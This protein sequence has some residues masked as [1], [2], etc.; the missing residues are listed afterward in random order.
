MLAMLALAAV[1]S[2]FNKSKVLE[3]PALI[4]LPSPTDGGDSGS[5]DF[6]INS[7]GIELSLNSLR[8]QKVS[9]FS[10]CLPAM[11]ISSGITPKLLPRP[12]R[13]LGPAVPIFTFVAR[14]SISDMEVKIFAI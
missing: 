8:T 11:E 3:K 5:I 10:I 9:S 6:L 13:S 4:V 1:D 7:Y 12:V 2:C 14:R